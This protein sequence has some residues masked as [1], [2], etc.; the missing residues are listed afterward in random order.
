MWYTVS[1]FQSKPLFFSIFNPIHIKDQSLH[2]SIGGFNIYYRPLKNLYFF[3][4]S[5]QI[6]FIVPVVYLF[7]FV[8]SLRERRVNRLKLI[9]IWRKV[10]ALHYDFFK[11]N[12]KIVGEKVCKARK[13]KKNDEIEVVW[14]K[15]IKKVNIICI[16][17][18]IIIIRRKVYL[19]YLG[20]TT[21]NFRFWSW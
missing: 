18:V 15:E 12:G 13:E 4:F 2:E 9:R 5:F 11:T 16:I 1:Y 14:E 19:I 3:L 8:V 21:I 10:E 6:F 7:F 17:I 20:E